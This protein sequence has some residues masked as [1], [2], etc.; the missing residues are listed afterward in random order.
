[1]T[2]IGSGPVGAGGTRDVA[3][4]RRFRDDDVDDVAAACGDPLTQRFLPLLPSPYTRA[5]AIGWIKQGA[6]AAFTGGGGAYA[7]ADPASDRLVGCVG[8]TFVR[9]G[10]AELGYWVAPWARGRGVATAAAWG[11]AAHAFTHGFARVILRAQ[12]ENPA[13]IRVALAAGFRREGIERDGGLGR[14][15]AR[16]DLI[17]FSRLATDAAERTPRPLPD[18]PGRGPDSPGELSDGVVT[19]RPLGPGDAADIIELRSRP[20]MWRYS[21][22]P[23]QPD[24]PELEQRC[25]RAESQWLA[26]DRAEITIRDAATGAFC[27]DLGL[28]YFEPSLQQAMIGYGLRS[29][30]RGRGYATRAV[31][32]LAE[33]AFGPPGI[34]RLIA[35]T[36]PHNAASQRVLERAGFVR[37]AYQRARLPGPDGTRVDDIQ[38]VLVA[39]DPTVSSRPG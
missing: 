14:Y 17:L 16:H 34:V 35:G 31:R 13:S 25:A 3:M 19:L 24:G 39:G 2:N 23:R 29:E 8:L 32:L 36:A 33:W 15:G 7:V 1:V 21:V 20:E 18:L 28:Y 4:L 26:G 6:P 11:L 22:P 10:V 5:D 12:P 9:T 30:W 37:E 38:Y 27:G